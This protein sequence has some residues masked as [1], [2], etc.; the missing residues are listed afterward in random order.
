MARPMKIS[1]ARDDF[2]ETVTR[3]A[4]KGERVSITRH[5][6]TLAAL[7]PAEDLE[8]LEKLED[9]YDI[10]KAEEALAE[11]GKSIPYSEYG[12]RR[13]SRRGK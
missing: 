13:K 2:S 9:E 8:L 11:P 1:E 5:G 7:V 3:V 4:Y 10:R 12:K 6:K